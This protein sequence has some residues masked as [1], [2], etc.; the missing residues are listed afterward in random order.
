M[1]PFYYIRDIIIL[2]VITSTIR[3]SNQHHVVTPKP[4]H[5]Q[6]AEECNHTWV[7]ACGH[8]QQSLDDRLFS[9]E[10]DIHEFN[11]DN[12]AAYV[13]VAL[14]KCGHRCTRHD[15]KS[16]TGSDASTEKEESKPSTLEHSTPSLETPT[17]TKIPITS[18]NVSVESTT[19]ASKDSNSSKET[20]TENA[21]TESCIN[22]TTIEDK[23]LNNTTNQTEQSTKTEENLPANDTITTTV[24]TNRSDCY[25]KD[26]QLPSTWETTV[27]AETRD[28][29]QVLRQRYGDKV[30][31]LRDTTHFPKHQT[32]VES[33]GVLVPGYHKEKQE[34]DVV[35]DI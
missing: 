32:I 11:C 26:C 5:C 33:D 28:F 8:N 1:A 7:P 9:D 12:N 21:T 34:T 35:N 10:C 23:T 3:Y 6:L 16:T 2:C 13:K 27:K 31:L 24:A 14:E 15:V 30:K 29:Y 20:A 4:D 22:K 17:T 25:P 18:E 19:Q